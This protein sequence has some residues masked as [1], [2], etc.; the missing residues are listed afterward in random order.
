MRAQLAGFA[1][2]ILALHLLPSLPPPF[3]VFVAGL[4]L[5]AVL[6]IGRRWVGLALVL[7]FGW[8][9]LVAGVRLAERLPAGADV[10]RD[11]SGKVVSLPERAADRVRFVLAPDR[12]PGNAGLPSRIRVD[13]YRPGGAASP[14]GDEIGAGERWR[15]TLRLRPPNAPFNQYGYDAE[16]Q[17]LLAGIGAS[18]VVQKSAAE[19]LTPAA[20]GSLLAYR[21]DLGDWLERTLPARTSAL[22]RAL[23]L[24]D[25]S[26]FDDD[27]WARY[28]ATGT[29]HLVAISGLH[30]G[31]V[32]GFGLALCRL[33]LLAL[34][35]VTR[36]WPALVLATWGGVLLAAA[37]GVLSGLLLPS[38]RALVM[39]LA[40]ALVLGTQRAVR[41]WQ[42]WWLAFAGVLALD[43]SAALG[44]GFWLSFGAVA[45][46]IYGF[47]AGR[48]PRQWFAGLAFAQLLLSFGL[49]PL[50]IWFF[51]RISLVGP[52]V[53]LLA[54]PL[55]GL[56]ALP[57][58]FMALLLHLAGLPA[59]GLLQ[60]A[61]WPLQAFEALLAFA[62]APEWAVLPGHAGLPAVLM[63][64]AGLLWLFAPRPVPGRGL[65]V[66][67]LLPLLMPRQDAPDTGDFAAT[68]FDVG[69]GLAVA[70]RTPEHLLLYDTGPGDGH[71]RDW[72]A[73]AVAP[74]LRAYGAPPLDLVLVSH[75]DLDHRGGLETALAF[76]P[77]TIIGS[78][79]HYAERCTAGRRWVWDGVEFR[80]LH[81]GPHLPYLGNDSSCVLQV[82]GR[83][84][85]L[86][87]PGDLGLA[88]EAA[89]LARHDD[90]D[91][92]AEILVAGH[93]GSRGSTS[94]AW[95]D[96]V[97]PA[98]TIISQGRYNRF[99]FPHHEV[100]ERLAGA[101]SAVLDTGACGGIT[102]RYDG[103]Q[104]TARGARTARRWWRAPPPAACRWPVVPGG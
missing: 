76:R 79:P 63:A 104:W 48:G 37:Y 67:W 86:L 92:G 102:L 23:L 87:L 56:L 69:Q 17:F 59:D 30:I 35:G 74:A 7:G 11:V 60:I 1:A 46:L 39:L 81:P 73:A 88:G 70:V 28:T 66:V 62:A 18:G 43:P 78:E 49:A 24:G 15:F 41:P 58:M 34:P 96:A 83:H 5:A 26:G 89:L 44:A 97:R 84:G 45:W 4:P 95:L 2:G 75:G 91:L 53:N 33:L 51:G 47:A 82:S 38:R 50:G 85:R 16:R 100:L 20:P 12:T 68:V 27:D 10:V 54:V 61:S 9:V 31:L 14:P 80:I 40:A 64:T 29:G 25:R 101:G 57:L 71:G 55:V 93:H 94:P 90:G 22:A 99:G 98:L 32:A 72:L 42:A 36:R 21:A 65:A 13:W 3:T 77:A 8:G 52:L 103:T 19:R 6:A